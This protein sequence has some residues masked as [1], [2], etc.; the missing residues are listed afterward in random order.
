MLLGYRETFR[1]RP[2]VEARS[3][4]RAGAVRRGSA[5]SRAALLVH[6]E[7]V[8]GKL[9]LEDSMA[10]SLGVGAVRGSLGLLTQRQ[11]GSYRDCCANEQYW[12]S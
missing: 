4:H 10:L 12:V 8:I 11:C 6:P 3:V 7:A 5:Y 1:A 9:V 2:G